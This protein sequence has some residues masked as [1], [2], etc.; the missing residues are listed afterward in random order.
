MTTRKNRPVVSRRLLESNDW[1]LRGKGLPATELLRK[2]DSI[3]KMLNS[4]PS[5]AQAYVENIAKIRALF[6]KHERRIILM[7]IIKKTRPYFIIDTR[8]TEQ[9]LQKIVQSIS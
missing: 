2:R 6:G 5:P 4:S 3:K 8:S 9:A 1:F 7:R